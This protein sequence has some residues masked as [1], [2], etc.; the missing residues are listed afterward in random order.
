MVL[1]KRWKPLW[2]SVSTLDLVDDR[3][4]DAKES[5]PYSSF[6]K[7]VYAAILSRGLNQPIKNFTLNCDDCPDSDVKVWLNAAIQRQLE[8]LYIDLSPSRLP[9]TI[10][11]CTTLAV[12]KLRFVK[13][14]AISYV[15]LPSLKTLHLENIWFD[16]PQFLMELLYGCPALEDLK[17][18]EIIFHDYS[19]EGKVRSLS[20]LV[21]ADVFFDENFFIPVKAF[22]NVEFLRIDECDGDIPVFPNLTCMELFL[23]G[24]I[25]F[26]VAL[27]M[28]NHCPK[29]QVVVFNFTNDDDDD[30]DGDVWPYPQ[31]VPECFSSHLTKC[32][33]KD[34]KGLDRHM[35]FARYVME[36]STSLRTM[37]MTI[38]SYCK[39]Q[40]KEVQ[41]IK[42]LASYSRSS[43][44]CKLLFK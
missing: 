15:Y 7:F 27:D 2:P 16:K 12:F 34:F 17:A 8:N 11:T 5:K 33:L 40:K 31:Y 42:E 9:C 36:N 14:D 23:G 43:P 20:K 10:L 18:N 30:E 21:R 39:N 6:I 13:F 19:F 32:F 35:R 26:S 25:Q 1:S 38:D 44:V 28:L 22:R 41:M 37:S 29:L 24:S 3:Y 4:L